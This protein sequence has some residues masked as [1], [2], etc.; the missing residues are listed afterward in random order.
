MI[1]DYVHG[2]SGS[3]R[4]LTDLLM[5]IALPAAVFLGLAA[6]AFGMN[7]FIQRENP[8][9]NRI[10]WN[11]VASTGMGVTMLGLVLMCCWGGLSAA[12]PLTRED[13]AWRESA[14]ATAN[15]APDAPAVYQYGPALASLVEHT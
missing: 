10:D 7:S 11:R 9:V 1:S 5:R 4:M 6:I 12:L 15:P 3:L 14:D 8:W 13:A 2:V